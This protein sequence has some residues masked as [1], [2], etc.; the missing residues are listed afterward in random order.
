V[1]VLHLST[2]PV[3]VPRH[4]GQ[5]RVANLMRVYEA[6]GIATRLIA[7]YEPEYYTGDLVGSA[8]IPFPADSTHRNRQFPFCT[9]LASGEFL[10][11]DAG[12]WKEL[13]R[14]VASFRPDVIQLEQPWLWPAAKRLRAEAVVPAFRVV[15]SSQNIEAPL[16]RRLLSG[17]EQGLVGPIIAQIES[18]EREIVAV[19]DLTIAVT[20]SDATVYHEWGARHVI[21]A[22]NGIV[23]RTLDPALVR[24]REARLDGRRFALFVG[25]AYPPNVTGFWDMFAPS[26]AF[27]APDELVM[28][29][30]GISTIILDAPTCRAWEQLNASRIERAGVQSEDNLA[31]LLS[32][33]SCVVLPI[34]VGGGSNIK[35]AE[36]ILSGKPIVGTTLSFRGYETMTGLPRVHRTDEPAEFRRL[37][38]RALEGSLSAGGPERPEVRRRVLWNETLSLVPGEIAAL[39]AGEVMR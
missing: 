12:A 31:V 2:Y 9:D 36:A 7:V 18:L 13:A 33:A 20:A 15:Y 17:Y 16:K 25:S 34:T 30:G 21:V 3:E 35:T 32:L 6:A 22:P 27:L 19:A 37:V 26:L 38:K 29:V 1:R 24:A 4:G 5:A 28:V 10:A 8:D 11:R 14:N 23:E 39:V